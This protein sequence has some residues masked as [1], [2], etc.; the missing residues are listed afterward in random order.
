MKEMPGMIS[1]RAVQRLAWHTSRVMLAGCGIAIGGAMAALRWTPTRII[2]TGAAAVV[3]ALVIAYVGGI[4]LAAF[5]MARA[6]DER[7]R[8]AERAAPS[9][10]TSDLHATRSRWQR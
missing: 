5:A 10:P 7:R 1:P 6:D 2:A 9:A 4:L 8:R 3:V